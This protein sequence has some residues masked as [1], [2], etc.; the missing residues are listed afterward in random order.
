MVTESPY[1][2]ADGRKACALLMSRN[3]P[4]PTAIVCGNDVLALGALVECHARRLKVP[5]D[6]SIVGFDNL[7]F[8]M[9][10]NPPLTTIDVPAEEMGIAAASYILGNLKG[11]TVSPHN[12]VEVELILRESSAPPAV[13]N[14][15]LHTELAE[16]PGN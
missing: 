14:G 13:E 10:S 5:Y 11:E 8:S 9:H 3:D 6:V 4:K 15:G 2:I 1:S 7:E 16:F 12:P